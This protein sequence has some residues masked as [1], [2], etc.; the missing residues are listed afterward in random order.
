MSYNVVTLLITLLAY[1]QIIMPMFFLCYKHAVIEYFLYTSD[2][3]VSFT[4][5]ENLGNHY[6]YYYRTYFKLLYCI[7]ES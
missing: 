2:I 7:D 1:S 6:N 5:I 4:R 3:L